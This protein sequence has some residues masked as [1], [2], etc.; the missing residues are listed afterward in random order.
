MPVDPK[1]I[2]FYITLGQV[3]MEMVAPIVVGAL[4]DHY[5]HWAPWG[6]I[7]GAVLGFIGGMGHLLALLNRRNRRGSTWPPDSSP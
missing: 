7:A 2:G 4:A 6:T 3:G 5:F 1:Q